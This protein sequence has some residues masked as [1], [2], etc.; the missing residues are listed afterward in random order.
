MVH[1]VEI[2]L[3]WQFTSPDHMAISGEITVVG[4]YTGEGDD[5]LTQHAEVIAIVGSAM[6]AVWELHWRPDQKVMAARFECLRNTVTVTADTKQ[7]PLTW[8]ADAARS[9]LVES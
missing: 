9:L 4:A 7:L 2:N 8:V 1:F 5:D 3:S 6:M